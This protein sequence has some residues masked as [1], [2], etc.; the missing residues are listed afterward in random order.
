[1]LGLVACQKKKN[2][3]ESAST[4]KHAHFCTKINR[5]QQKEGYLSWQQPWLQPL[6]PHVHPAHKIC[7]EYYNKSIPYMIF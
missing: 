3:K 4:C 2:R 1:M 7:C 6:T 5:M